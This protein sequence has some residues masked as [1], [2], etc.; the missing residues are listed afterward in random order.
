MYVNIA[1]AVS[2]FE[3]WPTRSP[4][5]TLLTFI[6]GPIFKC[7]RMPWQLMIQQN[8]SRGQ[9]TCPIEFTYAYN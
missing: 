6:Y 1:P 9:E 7:L 2:L 4:D 8:Y 5:L 3:V